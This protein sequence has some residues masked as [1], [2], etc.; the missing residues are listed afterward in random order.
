MQRKTSMSVLLITHDLA[1]VAEM[2]KRVA[3][4]Y[5]GMIVE[6]APVDE[7]FSNPL[8]PYTQGLLNCIPIPGARG[9]R[10]A[11][12]RGQ[13]VDLQDL[14][15]GCSFAPRCPY[16]QDICQSERPPLKSLNS[17]D[18]HMSACVLPP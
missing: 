6:E 17:S 13:P 15:R 14:P 10:L 4:M 5:A 1:V 2:A 8:H 9:R 11:P 7:L 18:S 3:V 12:I 16:V